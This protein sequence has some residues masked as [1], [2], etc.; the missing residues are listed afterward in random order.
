M[1]GATST[2]EEGNMLNNKP[3]LM[4]RDITKVFSSRRSVFKTSK[5]I[6]VNSVTLELKEKEIVGL[7]GESGSGKTTLGR[8]LA[9]M[10][11][12]D[13]GQVY[14]MGKKLD[15]SNK[16][17]VKKFKKDVQYVFQ[18]PFSSLPPYRKVKTLLE[19]V[20]KAYRVASGADAEKKINEILTSVGLTPADQMGQKRPYELSGGQRQRVSLARALAV[21][22][23]VI[24]ADEPVSMLDVT[25]RTGILELLRKIRDNQGISIIYITHDIVTA[26][27]IT[28]VIYVMYRGSILEKAPSNEILS[29]PMHPYTRL[30]ISSLPSFV[31]GETSISEIARDE[32]DHS[33]RR[34][35]QGTPGSCPFTDRCPYKRPICESNRPDLT[36]VRPDHFVACFLY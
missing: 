5:V 8:I 21:S 33:P 6:A 4:A 25:I 34:V 29:N 31:K 22:P 17:E 35:L 23:K 9:G 12:P 19:E 13:Q 36:E 7:I 11:K 27:A 20:L 18:D 2:A 1:P 28:D 26:N 30:L 14:Y 3:I 32:D 16:T 10:Y 24:I 15:Y